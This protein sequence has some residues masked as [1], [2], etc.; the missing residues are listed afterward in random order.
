MKA[1]LLV[2]SH[3][4]T[5]VVGFAIGVYVLPIL[6]A[7]EKTKQILILPKRWWSE[8]LVAYWTESPEKR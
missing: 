2:V 4:L 5:L 8:A 7:P 6:I 3:A 1:I